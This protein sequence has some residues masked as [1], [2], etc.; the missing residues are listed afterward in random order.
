MSPGCAVL[1]PLPLLPK[2]TGQGLW[3][4][5]HPWGT[6]E[7]WF[8]RQFVSITIILREALCSQVV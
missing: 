4:W 2:Q 8:F 3:G 5:E 1:T 6:T 7:P